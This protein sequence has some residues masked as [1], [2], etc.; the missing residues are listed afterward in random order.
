MTS[1]ITARVD[2]DKRKVA[3]DVFA[4]LGISTSGAVN[5][6]ICAV[7]RTHGIPFPL[8]TTPEATV[9]A[10][11]TEVSPNGN[12]LKLGIADGKFPFASNFDERFVEM[13]REIADL[14]HQSAP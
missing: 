6:F 14:F 4:E 3:E 7:A 1:M 12:S 5:L 10:S 8:V 2:A 11:K 9:S 13:D